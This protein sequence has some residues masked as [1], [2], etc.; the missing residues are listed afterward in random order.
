MNHTTRL[1]HAGL[2]LLVSLGAGSAAH[3]DTALER[4][5]FNEPSPHKT[6]TKE[7]SSVAVHWA[8]YVERVGDEAVEKQSLI[9]F[10]RARA[11]CIEAHHEMG[12]PVAEIKEWPTRVTSMRTD[13]YVAA[14][15]IATYSHGTGYGINPADC[16]LLE[17]EGYIVLMRSVQGACTVDLMA[18]TATHGCAG[19]AEGPRPMRKPPVRSWAP[20]MP[21]PTV[22]SAL[23]PQRTG[24]Q[25]KIA[26]VK[27]DVATNPLDADHGTYCYARGGSFPGHGPHVAADGTALVI[28]ATSKNGFVFQAE[29]ASLDMAVSSSIFMPHRAAGIRILAEG[30]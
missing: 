17:H 6:L 21:M 15:R 24:E 22:V 29:Q 7:G 11:E 26:G 10:R 2:C 4:Q 14:D 30:E 28:E 27:C 5:I 16:G 12:L 13:V 3:A 1:K 9:D 18:R 19:I 25:R 23:I 20:V 8:R